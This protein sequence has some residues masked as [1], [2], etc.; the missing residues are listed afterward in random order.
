M[1]RYSPEIRPEC[2]GDV[3]IDIRPDPVGAHESYA[4]Q[5]SQTS[6]LRVIPRK[7]HAAFAWAGVGRSK[8]RKQKAESRKQK[9]ESKE[10]RAKSR[11]PS[12]R[13]SSN[14]F[15]L[16]PFALCSF[17]LCSLISALC[18]YPDPARTRLP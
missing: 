16:L 9:A 3:R 17:A 14:Q 10:Q 11:N 12:E 6:V 8:S 5:G 2:T 18:N 13:L 1:G 7:R 4:R 15:C